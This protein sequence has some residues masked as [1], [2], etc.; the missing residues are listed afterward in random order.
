[1]AYISAAVCC[2]RTEAISFCRPPL[3]NTICWGG[4]VNI[5]Y[6]QIACAKTSCLLKKIERVSMHHTWD[7][8]DFTKTKKVKKKSHLLFLVFEYPPIPTNK[9]PN[10]VSRMVALFNIL[11]TAGQLYRDF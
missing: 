3:I 11:L 6:L 7:N 8:N 1:M 4:K 10:I 5:L 9:T 2:Q